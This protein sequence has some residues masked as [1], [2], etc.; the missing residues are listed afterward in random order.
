MSTSRGFQIGDRVL[1]IAAVILLGVAT[2]G[3]AWCGLQSSLWNGRQGD[4]ATEVSAARLDANRLYNTATQQ[5]A[6]DADLLTT[7][8]Q[9]VRSGDTKLQ[10]FYR[11]VVMRS[12]FL[13]FLD[14]WQGMIAEGKTPPRLLEDQEYLTVM[15]DDYEQAD[16]RVEALA[17]EADEAGRTADS[18]VLLTVV[19]AI[20]LFF[21][22]VTSSFRFP[23]VRM[24]LLAGCL[25][26]VGLAAARLV[27]LPIESSTVQLL[28]SLEE[29]AGQS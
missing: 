14:E 7:Y 6:Y 24:A 8:A 13:P 19:L 10:Q 15:R 22:G 28:P 11:D 20:A 4:V 26:S 17:R 12:E 9:A 23:L 25:V 16:Q 21:A 1:E 5:I 18:Y 3:T 27:D 2:V 29:P